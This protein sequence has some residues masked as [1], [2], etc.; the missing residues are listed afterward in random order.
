MLIDFEPI[1]AVAA[2]LAGNDIHEA[3]DVAAMGSRNSEADLKP[4]KESRTTRLRFLGADRRNPTAKNDWCVPET[5]ARRISRW[6]AYTG[7]RH[8]GL[9]QKKYREHNADTG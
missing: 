4:P 2:T 1:S 8:C 9:C 3:A 5:L 6:R 7:T